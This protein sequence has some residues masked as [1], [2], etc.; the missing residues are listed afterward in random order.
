MHTG[1]PHSDG[2]SQHTDNIRQLPQQPLSILNTPPSTF[3]HVD[4]T[5]AQQG[6]DVIGCGRVDGD[7]TAHA[8]SYHQDG[9]RGLAIQNLTDVTLQLQSNKII[10]I[11]I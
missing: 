4:D 7:S 1:D 10:H 9:G 3:H 2:V 5:Q 6:W 11:F 8:V